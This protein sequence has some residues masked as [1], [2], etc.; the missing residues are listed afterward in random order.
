MY[1]ILNMHVDALWEARD[2]QARTPEKLMNVSNTMDFRDD[3]SHTALFNDGHAL[4]HGILNVH[5]DTLQARTPE[6]LMNVGKVKVGIS[7]GLVFQ[8]V[9]QALCSQ[10]R[11]TLSVVVWHGHVENEL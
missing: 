1:G 10:R 4:P 2:I 3:V 11:H 7:C 8:T 9:N 5:V 6:M